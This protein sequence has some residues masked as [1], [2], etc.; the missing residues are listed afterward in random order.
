MLSLRLFKTQI[1][2][3]FRF[4]LSILFLTEVIV[5]ILHFVITFICGQVFFP[6]MYLIMPLS[7][8]GVFLLVFILETILTWISGE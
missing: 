4:I 1:M 7:I 3:Y 8:L 5:G 2:N 6:I